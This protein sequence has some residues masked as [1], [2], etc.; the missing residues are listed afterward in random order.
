MSHSTQFVGRGKKKKYSLSSTDSTIS[1]RWMDMILDKLRNYTT[2]L[3]L[4]GAFLVE[5]GIQSGTIRSYFSAIKTIL[6]REK[7]SVNIDS[8]LLN[9][10]T[11]ACKLVNDSVRNRLPIKSKLLE[12]LLFEL[13]RIFRKQHYLETL[14]KAMFLIGYCGLF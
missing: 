7:I 6:A 1:S 8:M 3:S 5:N 9:M 12:V 11:K 4:Y 13:E 10:L 2:R 14:Y